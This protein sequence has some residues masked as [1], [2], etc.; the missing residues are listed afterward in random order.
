MKNR[1]YKIKIPLFLEKK[2][3]IG[4]DILKNNKNKLIL[5]KE[6]E[7]KRYNMHNI[8]PQVGSSISDKSYKSLSNFTIKIPLNNNDI[9]TN[10]KDTIKDDIIKEQSFTLFNP[11]NPSNHELIFSDFSSHSSIS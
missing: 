4:E 7:K 8:H 6:R 10:M 2:K 11:N 3:T 1:N 5:F 9:D